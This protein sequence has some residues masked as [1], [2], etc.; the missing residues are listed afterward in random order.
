[1]IVVDRPHLKELF[2][3]HES[4]LHFLSGAVEDADFSYSFKASVF[5]SIHTRAIRLNLNHNLPCFTTD[6]VDELNAAIEDEFGN[7]VG[8]G[9]TGL[10][11]AYQR[12]D[13]YRWVR[14]VPHISSKTG[15]PYIRGAATVYYSF[16]T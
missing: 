14:K 5:E 4:D 1:M 8:K 16:L 12:L 3:A 10:D 15:L 6:M 2:N 9:M 11:L 13:A 7:V